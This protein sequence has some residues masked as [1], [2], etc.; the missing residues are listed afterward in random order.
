[1]GEKRGGVLSLAE[2]AD[3]TKGSL[4]SG[5]PTF[6]PRSISTD[7]RTMAPGDVFLALKGERFDGHDF[8]A[9]AL[10]KGASGL[11]VSRIGPKELELALSKGAGVVKV[12]DTLWALG[13]LAKKWRELHPVCAIGITGSNGKTTT[14]EMVAQVLSIGRKV[15]KNEGNL[16]NLIGLPL[17]LLKLDQS[18]E[19]AVLELGTSE[20]GEIARLCEILRPQLGLITQIAPAH[21]EKLGSLEGIAR[22]KGELFRSLS[23]DDVAIVNSD[24]PH[25]MAL[26]RECKAQIVT[27]GFEGE[28]TIKGERLRPFSQRGASFTLVL[29]GEKVRVRLKGQGMPILRCALAASAACWA[30]GAKAEEISKGLESFKP[31]WGRLNIMEL[32]NGVTLIDDS[33]N[34]NPSSMSSALEI[35]CKGGRGRKVAILGEMKELG[36]MAL[37]A[38]RELGREAARKGVDLLVAIG[39]WSGEVARGAMEAKSRGRPKEIVAFERLEDCW[40]ALKGFMRRGDRILVKGSRGASMERVVEALKQWAQGVK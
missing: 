15:L 32:A 12:R 4:L 8:T 5:N 17:T 33:Y 21:L 40:E 23:H 10:E 28:A 34:A 16:N 25:V 14:K 7:T 35:L 39:P 22:E 27:Y 2:I 31:Q 9:Q 24:D 29:P 30:M 38:H 11:I 26:S 18:H 19:V 3:V 1:M 36:S 20:P 6:S 37:A 13:E